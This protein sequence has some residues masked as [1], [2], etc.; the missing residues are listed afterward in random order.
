M[1]ARKAVRHECACSEVSAPTV[2]QVAHHGNELQARYGAPCS[3]AWRP[4]SFSPLILRFWLEA[5]ARAGMQMGLAYGLL[6][7]VWQLVEEEEKDFLIGWILRTPNGERAIRALLATR[8][9]EA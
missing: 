2:E 6:W 8:A 7:M 1:R 4:R 9:A 3:L 5:A